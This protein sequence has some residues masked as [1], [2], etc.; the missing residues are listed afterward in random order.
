MQP[1]AEADLRHLLDSSLLQANADTDD[2]V[3]APATSSRSERDQ[4]LTDT[5][6]AFAER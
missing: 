5:F 1:G 6:R 3:D 2:D 4:A